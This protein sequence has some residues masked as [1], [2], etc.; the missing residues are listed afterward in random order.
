MVLKG[1]LILLRLCSKGYIVQGE[2]VSDEVGDGRVGG[3]RV[4]GD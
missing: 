3:E 1:G 4:C 2:D